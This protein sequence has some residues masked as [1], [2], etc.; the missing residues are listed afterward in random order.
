VR[1]RL[2]KKK[3]AGQVPLPPG[4]FREK[5]KSAL[6]PWKRKEKEKGG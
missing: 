1:G 2:E 6:G 4:K 3:K 5:K